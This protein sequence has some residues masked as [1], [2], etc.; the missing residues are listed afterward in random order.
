MRIFSTFSGIGGFELGLQQ[1]FSDRI[2]GDGQQQATETNLQHGAHSPDSSSELG[3][4]GWQLPKCVGYSEID[5]YAIKVYEKQFGRNICGAEVC[6]G[7]R[8][9]TQGYGESEASQQGVESAQKSLRP[10]RNSTNNISTGDTREVS[11]CG[12]K[13][14]GDITKI[15]AEELPDF[16]CL[17]GGFPCQAFSI[18]GKRKGFEDTRGTL[19]FDLARI[20]RA[21]QPRLFVFEN[22]KGLLSHDGGRTFKTII[23]TIDELGYDCQWQVL[24]SKNYGVPQ[25]RERVYIVGHLRGTPRPEVFPITGD[26][27]ADTRLPGHVSNTLTARYEGAQA[28][29]TYIGESKL[30]AQEIRQLN[31]PTHSND[32]VYA[33]DGIST[34]LNTMQGGNRQPFIAAQRGGY[35]SEGKTE[36]KFEPRYDGISS[37][38]TAVQKDNMVVDPP[39][40]RRLT[41]VECERLQG[42]PEIEV[43]AIIEVCIDHQKN[44]VNV[45]LKSLKSQKLVGTV[46]RTESV[47]DA[48]SAKNSSPLNDPPISKPAQPNVHIRL[49]GERVVIRNQKKSLLYASGA[50]SQGSSALPMPDDVF[51]QTIAGILRIAERIAPD[52]KAESALSVNS[53]MGQENG[54]NSGKIFGC[55]ITLPVK[56][57]LSDSTTLKESLKYTT[58]DHLDLEKLGL[59]LATLSYYVASTMNG[60]TDDST[61]TK[62]ISTFHLS[63]RYGWTQ[64]GTDGPISDSQRYKMCGNA[65]TTNV[66]QAVF[67]RIFESTTGVNQ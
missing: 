20:L 55:G 32:R 13:N 47:N 33:S 18:A 62:S 43:D 50:T 21:K 64:Y 44:S 58:S 65:V 3:N 35:N 12:P 49:E 30:N 37:T 46:A 66:V 9:S 15:N 29:G 52:G 40:I 36:Q 22:V 63:E 2:L 61:K 19:F 5:K 4:G 59:N 8:Q 48:S 67:E 53:S 34:T 1:A 11:Y 51:A 38:L 10:I 57:A 24:N 23:Q 27:G 14:Y 60:Y 39:R 26:G 45:E 56:D 42:F 17:V 7:H 31:Q 28:V 54:K 16:D 41:P 25:N 6:N